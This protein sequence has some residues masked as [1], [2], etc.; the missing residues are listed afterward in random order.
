MDD[1]RPLFA[2]L[3]RVEAPDVW[4][5]V[6]RRLAA[7]G[8]TPV[9]GVVSARGSASRPSTWWLVAAALV[10]LALI[11]GAL[12]VA[13]N[14]RESPLDPP[15]V[16]TAVPAPTRAPSPTSPPPASPTASPASGSE[17]G[18]LAYTVQGQ[19]FTA[20]A[21]GTDA[22]PLTSADGYALLPRWSPDGTRIAFVSLPCTS[23]R[24]CDEKGSPSSIVV[25]RADGSDRREI[26]RTSSHVPTLA[27]SPDG[28]R[29]AFYGYATTSAAPARVE[30]VGADGTGGRTIGDG[31]LLEWSPDGATIAYEADDGTHL[32]APDGTGDHLMVETTPA[33]IAVGA[34]WSPDGTRIA[35]GLDKVGSGVLHRGTASAWVVDASGTGAHRMSEVP[36]GATFVGWRPDGA[37]IAWLDT[38]TSNPERRWPLVVADPD[39]SNSQTI[40]TVEAGR[41][42]WS[43]DGRRL[44][45]I[46]TDGVLVLDPDGVAAPVRIA[47]G[48][49]SWQPAP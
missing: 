24:P 7:S 6:Q 8:A 37:K 44:F 2:S 48:D 16:T 29:L 25:M 10:G 41:V 33:G 45:V 32:V 47:A 36:E 5:E 28:S 22:R 11:A 3:D 27:W 26:V 39:G 17:G 12:I 42:D 4:D 19:L 30:V 1:L 40:G 43:P 15:A 35:F 49:A 21:S 38:S 18:R 13:G 31:P 9:V 46:Q 20:T 23:G 34:R 14:R